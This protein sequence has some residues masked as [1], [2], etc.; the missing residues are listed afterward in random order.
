MTDHGRGAPATAASRAAGATGG[1]TRVALG[2]LA[3]RITGL[4]R[5][6]AFAH[7]FGSSLA[8]D[9]FAF[10][11]RVPNF[12]QNLLGEGALSASFVPVYARLLARDEDE[13]ARRLAG[14]VFSILALLSAVLVL[15]GVLAAPWI[16][17]FFAPGFDSGTRELATQLTRILFPGLGLLV[18]AAWC[19]G[20]LNSHRHFF[21]AY[22]APVAWN[23]T[24][25]AAMIWFG[26]SRE[27]SALAIAVA[28]A[29]VAGSALQF[30]VQLPAVRQLAGA[31][32]P[33]LDTGDANLRTVLRNFVPVVTGRGVVQI[34]AWM[35]TVLASLVV[36]GAVAALSYAQ[37]IYM[38]PVALFGSAVSVAELPEMASEL[39][40][41]DE[42]ARK[43]RER[44]ESAKRRIAFLVVPSV[45][46]LVTLGDLMAG[47]I[48]LSGRFGRDDAVWVW[49]ILA[50]SAVGLLASVY[51]RLYASAFY[52]LRD[53]RTPM[54]CAIARVTLAIALAAGLSLWAPQ[55]LGI[56]AR[57]GVAGITVGSGIAGWVEF[58]LLRGALRRRVGEI[59]TPHRFTLS[60]WVLAG[61]AAALASVIR[62]YGGRAPSLSLSL[63][64]LVLYGALYLG[65]ARIMGIPES[66]AVF[67]RL[68]RFR[69]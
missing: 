11:F 4:I 18:L 15:A 17:A 28:W 1:A 53:P 68:R 34:S 19:L 43:L 45:V 32:R 33:S 67:A 26:G 50:G 61:L 27:G 37:L 40:S 24:M 5:Q 25:I 35:D 39:G 14:A 58:Q 55:A 47:V 59:G 49:G 30:A 31:L 10:A 6:R 62:V 57:W 29:A 54:Q 48:Y 38:L 51:G 64:G 63:A 2:I 23:V 69:R 44:I 7:F 21:L 12:L 41:D 20:I 3:S 42:V 46:A 8:A 22:V 60:L 65:F 56:H 52:A 9:A 13:A 66:G 36:P 16:V